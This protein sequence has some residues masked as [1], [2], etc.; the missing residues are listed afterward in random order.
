MLCRKKSVKVSANVGKGDRVYLSK[1]KDDH[2][3]VHKVVKC[4]GK[5]E[6]GGKYS[7][8]K[9]MS[10]SGI[11]RILLRNHNR[12]KGLLWTRTD[13]RNDPH[14]FSVISRPSLPI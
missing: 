10:L 13:I 7:P 2:L 14:R 3:S 6:K 5:R 4:R 8:F 12:K 1:R 9:E 11:I